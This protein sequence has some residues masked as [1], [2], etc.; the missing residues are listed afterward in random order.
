MRFGIFDQGLE[1]HPLVDTQAIGRIRPV[2]FYESVKGINSIL[3]KPKAT[4]N[5]FPL[6][7]F[8]AHDLRILTDVSLVVEKSFDHV[9][10][11]L[12]FPDD[13]VG[14]VARLR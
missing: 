10:L 14:V 4:A 1:H 12:Y 8:D 3:A 5:S 11:V 13:R 6:L 9:V 2:A 7:F